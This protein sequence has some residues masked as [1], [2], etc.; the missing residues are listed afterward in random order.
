MLLHTKQFEK[1]PIK[2]IRSFKSSTES[3]H[4]YRRM[5]PGRHVKIPV[6]PCPLLS[7]QISPISEPS[8]GIEKN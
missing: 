3:E 8:S 2:T 1:L 4:G 5:V 7:H 6:R